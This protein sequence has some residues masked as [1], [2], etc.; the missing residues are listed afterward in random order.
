MNLPPG[1]TTAELTGTTT[2]GQIFASPVTVFNRDYSYYT[3]AQIN[4]QQA[5][6][7]GLRQEE[8]DRD[9]QRRSSPRRR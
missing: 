6:L 5:A 8:R 7:A 9:H 1:I 3:P 2:S 4:K